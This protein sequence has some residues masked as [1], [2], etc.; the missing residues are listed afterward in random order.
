MAWVYG[1]AD[2]A[3]PTLS[4]PLWRCGLDGWPPLLCSTTWRHLFLTE[5]KWLENINCWAFHPSKGISCF[6]PAYKVFNIFICFSVKPSVA[7]TG[8]NVDDKNKRMFM[9][10]FHEM[11][12][13][14]ICATLSIVERV[15]RGTWKAWL[16]ALTFV[17]WYLNMPHGFL[18]GACKFRQ[19]GWWKWW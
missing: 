13:R 15:S 18:F 7:V 5:P 10:W 6:H 8:Q 3:P 12:T 14:E 4:W 19:D 17:N 1:W 11:L 16:R 2:G 9:E